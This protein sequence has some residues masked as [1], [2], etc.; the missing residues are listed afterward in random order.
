MRLSRV[1]RRPTLTQ[2]FGTSRRTGQGTYARRPPERRAAHR[3][4]YVGL[5]M[6]YRAGALGCWAEGKAMF[7]LAGES[8]YMLV[9]LPDGRARFCT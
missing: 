9:H 5:S 6:N 1:R 2:R 4:C 7:A 3:R 8:G